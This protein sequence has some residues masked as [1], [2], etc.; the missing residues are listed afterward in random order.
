MSC[1]SLALIKFD[2]CIIGSR[3]INNQI[4]YDHPKSY[5][6]NDCCHRLTTIIVF[7]QLFQ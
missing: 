1:I 3:K 7:N 4:M 5:G 2:V 6:S